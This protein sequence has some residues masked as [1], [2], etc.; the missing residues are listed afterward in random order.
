[1]GSDFSESERTT[2]AGW[3][4]HFTHKYPTVGT[5]KEYDG[6]DFSSVEEEAKSQTPFGVGKDDATVTKSATADLGQVL[7][8]EAPSPEPAKQETPKQEGLVLRRGERVLIKND[9]DRPELN[10]TV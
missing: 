7:V 1:M 8:Q 3:Y 2:L 5:L 10:G 6:W 4:K 9:E